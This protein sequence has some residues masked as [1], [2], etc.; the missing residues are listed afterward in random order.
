MNFT[1]TYFY[2]I[3]RQDS[4]L[5]VS[6]ALFGPMIYVNKNPGKHIAKLAFV[7]T[8]TKMPNWH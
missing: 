1:L 3:A 2:D 6:L 7:L 5:G 8:C 4:H